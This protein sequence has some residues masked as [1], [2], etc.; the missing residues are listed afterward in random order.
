M[1]DPRTSQQVSIFHRCICIDLLKELFLSV[2]I[3]LHDFFCNQYIARHYT[4]S[5]Y[6]G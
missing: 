5:R 1:H 2:L 6:I 3:L 4:A